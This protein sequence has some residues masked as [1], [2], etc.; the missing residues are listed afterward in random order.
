MEDIMASGASSLLE[1]AQARGAQQDQA[2]FA[3]SLRFCLS[4]LNIAYNQ[5]KKNEMAQF[6]P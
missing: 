5:L 2:S 6:R 1:L 3:T 4:H